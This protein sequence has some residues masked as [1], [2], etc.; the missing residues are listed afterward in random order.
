M[1]FPKILAY[2]FTLFQPGGQVITYIKLLFA[3]FPRIFRPST[4]SDLCQLSL[5][6]LHGINTALLRYNQL[7][8]IQSHFELFIYDAA[9]LLKLNLKLK[10]I[11]NSIL[12]GRYAFWQ[13]NLHE[14]LKT[15]FESQSCHKGSVLTLILFKVD[16]N[17]VRKPI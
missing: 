11:K 16:F 14:S 10:F 13:H 2:Q 17:T 9:K 5:L 3:P 15:S 6:T 12:H 8:H 4:G 7:L 1:P